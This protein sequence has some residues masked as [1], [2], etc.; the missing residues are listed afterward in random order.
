MTTITPSSSPRKPVPIFIGDGGHR[1]E[2]SNPTQPNRHPYAIKTTSTSL[3]TRSN[4]TGPGTHSHHFYVP[5]SPSPSS[6][7][8][9][10]RSD[11]SGVRS[12]ALPSSPR[13]LPTPPT[14][15]LPT[16]SLYKHTGYVSAEDL[17]WRARRAETLHTPPPSSPIKVEDLPSNPKVWTATHLS[18]YLITALRVR[19]DDGL[20][21]PLAVAKDIAAF[22]KEARL[23]GRSFLRLTEQDIEQYVA[24][25]FDLDRVWLTFN[26]GWK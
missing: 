4:S 23:N 12:D 2:R 10:T 6:K 18:S 13:P 8:R 19:G 11:A 26:L 15:D 20:A 16:K 5:T 17:S 9:Y 7:H 3:L 14:L 22:V 24:F 21:L 1:G 25:L